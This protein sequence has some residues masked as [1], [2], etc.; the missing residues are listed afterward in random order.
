MKSF[1]KPGI[2]GFTLK[3]I[4]ILSMLIDHAGAARRRKSHFKASFRYWKC[5]SSR[6]L[7][8]HRPGHACHRAYCLSHFLFSAGGGICLH[9]A[10]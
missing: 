6:F 1:E 8:A 5:G 7:D 10:M 2:S 9:C 3:I 4:A